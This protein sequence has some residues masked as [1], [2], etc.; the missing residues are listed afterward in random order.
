MNNRKFCACGCRRSVADRRRGTKWATPQCRSDWRRSQ[1]PVQAG[2][3]GLQVSYRKALKQMT[4]A[5]VLNAPMDES[6]ACAI[7]YWW[8]REALPARQRQRLEAR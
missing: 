1:K 5:L 2:S 4:Q 6:Q 8:L 3:G 7:A